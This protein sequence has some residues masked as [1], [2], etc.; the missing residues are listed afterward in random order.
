MQKSI[1]AFKRFEKIWFTHE[2]TGKKYNLKLPFSHYVKPKLLKL[3]TYMAFLKR[4][5]HKKK[6]INCMYERSD[7]SIMTTLNDDSGCGSFSLHWRPI[8]DL[9][10]LSVLLSGCCLFD[11]FPISIF[12]FTKSYEPLLEQSKLPTLKIGRMKSLALETYK[13]VTKSNPEFLHNI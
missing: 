10:L 7:S 11:T 5:Q 6:M 12:N 3:S 1:Q 8:G 9:L 13:I 2:Q 4:V